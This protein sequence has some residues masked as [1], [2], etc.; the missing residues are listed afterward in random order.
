MPE[1]TSAVPFL[2]LSIEFRRLEAEWLDA[3]RESG[4]TGRFIMGPQVAGFEREA[5]EYLGVER[6]VAVANGTDA[7]WLSLRAL[8]IGPGDE[9]ITTP[10][11]FFA[12][13]EVISQVGATPV[14][15]DV[16]ENTFNLD[17]DQIADRITPNT[18]AIVPV[19]LFG[20][21]LDMDK[22]AALAQTSRLAVVEDCAQAFGARWGDAAVGSMGDTGCFSFYPTK[23]LGCYGDG[24]MVA[25]R[26]ADVAARIRHLRDHSAVAAYIH[27]GVGHNSRLDEIQAALLRIKLRA[28]DSALAERRRVASRYAERLDGLDVVLPSP[29]ADGDHVFNC[30]TV[31][32][33]DRDHVRQKLSDQ[34]IASAVYYPQPLHR[35]PVYES[36]GN[37]SGALPV[38]ES[39]CRQVISLPIFPDMTTAQVDHVCAVLASALGGVA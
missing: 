38:S 29:S 15:V 28:I 3:I 39:V 33:A 8:Q 37:R 32:V 1:L 19:H 18:R 6:A 11:T 12:T 35:Q 20:R 25:T 17:E 5:A 22:I 30:Y 24:G 26:R 14:F 21:P 36:L 16:R 34:G 13:A 27:D 4:A 23:V 2:D 10:F 7:L 9:V 31:R